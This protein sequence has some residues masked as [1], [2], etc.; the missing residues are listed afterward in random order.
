MVFYYSVKIFLSQNKKKNLE[1]G[2]ESTYTQ[3]QIMHCELIKLSI[4]LKYKMSKVKEQIITK[5]F[6]SWG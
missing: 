3:G 6:E 5:K 1:Q 4:S 2:K